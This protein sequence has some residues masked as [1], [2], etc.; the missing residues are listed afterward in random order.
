MK[1]LIEEL[2]AERNKWVSYPITWLPDEQI[3]YC[4]CCKK[5]LAK[6]ETK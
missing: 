5:K 2:E 1:D 4:A 3:Y 6:K